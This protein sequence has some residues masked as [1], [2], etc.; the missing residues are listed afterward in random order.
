MLAPMPR[1]ILFK[2]NA[3]PRIRGLSP[4]KGLKGQLCL[5]LTFLLRLFHLHK[6]FYQADCANQNDDYASQNACQF[7]R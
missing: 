4:C 3:R 7:L 1:P 2:V 6:E 5:L